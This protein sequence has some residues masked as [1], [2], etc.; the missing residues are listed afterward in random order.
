MIR[1]NDVGGEIAQRLRKRLFG[2]DAL[3]DH[4]QPGSNKRFRNQLGVSRVVLQQKDA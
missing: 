4:R 2:V 3:R 1:E